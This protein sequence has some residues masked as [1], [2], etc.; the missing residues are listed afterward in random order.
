MKV[1]QDNEALLNALSVL[2][3]EYRRE[4]DKAMVN[5]D[6]FRVYRAIKAQMETLNRM[7][8]LDMHDAL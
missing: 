3:G 6:A 1:Q 7:R 2:A 8:R 5:G 4:A